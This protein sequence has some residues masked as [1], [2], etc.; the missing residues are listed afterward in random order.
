MGRYLI[1][2][3]RQHPEMQEY[4]TERF[5]DDGNVAVI[6]DRREIAAQDGRAR[7]NAPVN[8]AGSERRVRRDV[9]GELRTRSHIIVTLS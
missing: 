6:L 2:V 5:R 7:K 9:G 3:S 1:V 8:N 4:L